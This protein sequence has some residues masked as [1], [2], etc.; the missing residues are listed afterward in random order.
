MF[1]TVST[2]IHWGTGIQKLQGHLKSVQ[3][4]GEQQQQALTE[5]KK[6]NRTKNCL[7]FKEPPEAPSGIRRGPKSHLGKTWRICKQ[8]TGWDGILANLGCL[9]LKSPRN[10]HRSSSVHLGR[11]GWNPILKTLSLNN[12]LPEPLRNDGRRPSGMTRR[13]SLFNGGGGCKLEPDRGMESR[14]YLQKDKKHFKTTS[15]WCK[16]RKVSL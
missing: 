12:G 2:K 1:F 4:R 14:N 15:S 13:D 11:K 16:I 7:Q 3:L 10:T 5:L 6:H 8:K 9:M